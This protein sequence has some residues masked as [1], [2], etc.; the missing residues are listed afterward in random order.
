L[1]IDKDCTAQWEKTSILSSS[2]PKY[3]HPFEKKLITKKM[4]FKKTRF[5]SGSSVSYSKNI[6]FFSIRG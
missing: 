6:L 3:A 2:S 4:S 5:I 1:P